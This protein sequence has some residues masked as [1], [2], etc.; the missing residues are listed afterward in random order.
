[1]EP[2]RLRVVP[3]GVTPPIA[4]PGQVQAVRESLGLPDRFVLWVGTLE[5]RKNLPRLVEAMDE[6]AGVSLV[7]VGPVGWNLDGGDVLAPLGPRVHRVGEVDE[8][9]LSSL[10]AAASVFARPSLVEG[11]GLPV[12][13]AM[14]HG[15]PVVTSAGTATAEVSGG[16]ARLVDP[17]D[18]SAIA[19][20]IAAALQHDGTTTELIER[21]LARAGELSWL[22][23]ARGYTT[24]FREVLR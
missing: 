23:T 20:G 16:A 8:M 7:V 12:L 21:G 15:P 17:R 11:F 1:V 3:W 2:D 14:A 19:A 24:A 9:T 10:Y 13:E 18:P 22:A 5:P 6:V 4:S